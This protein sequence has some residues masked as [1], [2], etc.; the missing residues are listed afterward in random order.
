MAKIPT[1]RG[2]QLVFFACRNDEGVLA[3]VMATKPDQARE[4]LKK[5]GF[6]GYFRCPVMG[7]VRAKP[8]IVYASEK[9]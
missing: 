7:A 5:E 3:V 6:K 8:S 4:T 1:Y 2:K 9:P